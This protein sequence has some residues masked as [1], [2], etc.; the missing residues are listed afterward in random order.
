[1]GKD[2]ATWLNICYVA[3]TLLASY[4]AYKAIETVGVQFSW[5]D[6]YDQWYPLLNNVLALVLGVAAALWLR[7]SEERRSYHQSA[8]SEI[9]KVTWPTI[10][11]TKK[12][13]MVVV[14]VVAIFAVIL[15]FFDLLWSKVL[16]QILP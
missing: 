12:M 14:V 5:T 7:S 2:D 9:R 6:R 8:I 1:M 3:F 4:V 11:N 10:P 15:S 16:Q 13:T